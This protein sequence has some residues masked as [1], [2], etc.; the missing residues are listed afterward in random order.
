MLHGEDGLS[1]WHDTPM[2]SRVLACIGDSITY[3]REM[4]LAR[5]ERNWVSQ[6]ARALGEAAGV[7][8][9]DGFRGLWHKEEWTASG[10][11]TRATRDDPFD[12]VPF[13]QTWCSSGTAAD[14]LT[15]T[16]PADVVAD[17]TDI[18][19]AH[20]EGG[21]RWQ[22]RVDEQPWQCVDLPTGP[23]DNRLHRVHLP[24]AVCRTLRVRGYDGTAPCIAAIAGVD[25]PGERAGERRPT[26]HNLGQANQFLGEFCRPSAGDPLALLDALRPHLAVV[27]FSNDVRVGIVDVFAERLRRLIERVEPYADV[28]VMTPFEQRGTR[29]VDDA[30][31]VAG[32]TEVRSERAQFFRTDIDAPLRGS[33]I[34]KGAVVIGVPAPDRARMS[35]PATATSDAGTLEVVVRRHPQLQATYRAFARAVAERSGCSTLDLYEAWSA[36][37]GEGW[38]P[39]YAAGLMHDGLHPSQRGHDDIARRVVARLALDPH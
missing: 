12:V 22:Y 1:R 28:L 15:W 2:Q 37:V 13:G 26:V 3:D 24:R 33:A 11:W 9:N 20:R 23:P 10:S 5:V 35:K 14:E 38:A 18:L 21:G 19:W 4:P 36:E 29:R 7:R 30:S 8:A 6:V 34:A 39:A 27:M 32:S 31:T 25:V 16:R 17:C